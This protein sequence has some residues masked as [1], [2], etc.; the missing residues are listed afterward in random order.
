MCWHSYVG[1]QVL[2]YD[3]SAICQ[4]LNLFLLEAD[5]ASTWLFRICWIRYVS[6]NSSRSIFWIQKIFC[7]MMCWRFYVGMPVLTLCQDPN[8]F[9]PEADSK[10]SGGACLSP[11]YI[12]D[13]LFRKSHYLAILSNSINPWPM[14]LTPM[15]EAIRR[16]IMRKKRPKGLKKCH[17]DLGISRLGARIVSIKLV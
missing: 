15:N 4:D 17:Y 5:E 14:T 8:L 9:L 3:V 11:T 13:W 2:T 7:L 1:M 10:K 6:T 12:S 16:E